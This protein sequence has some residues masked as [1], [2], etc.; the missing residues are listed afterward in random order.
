MAEWARPFTSPARRAASARPDGIVSSARRIFGDDM[1][2][3]GVNSLPCRRPAPHLEDATA[4][5]AGRLKCALSE[6]RRD[7][8]SNHHVYNWR[9]MSSGATSQE[10]VSEAGPPIP[11]LC[12]QS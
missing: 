2:R 8:A 4:V 10:C 3:C 6:R 9:I 5:S 12:R 11:P 7:T 1:E